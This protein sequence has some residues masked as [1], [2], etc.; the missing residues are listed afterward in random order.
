MTRFTV[1]P[2]IALVG[3]ALLLTSVSARAAEQVGVNAAVKGKVT[4]QSG[5]T[6]AQQAEIKKPVFLGDEVNSEK[7][8]ALQVMLKDQSVFTVGPQC[9]L[10]IDKFV[11][12]PSN[13][14]NQISANVKKGMFRFMSGKVSKSNPDDVAIDTPV[15]SMGIRG[16]IV[17]GLVGAEAVAY[18]INAGIITAGSP[19]D[20]AG[21]TLV[22]LRGPG[23]ANQGKD[24][25]GLV[26]ITSGGRTARLTNA[27][28][29]AFV[30][31][32]NSAPII[33]NQVSDE[34]FE[35]FSE[36]LR[37]RPNLAAGYM[38]FNYDSVITAGVESGVLQPLDDLDNPLLSFDWP[39]DPGLIFED[40]EF[41]CGP[42]NPNF[43]GCEALT[44][45]DDMDDMN[46]MQDT[47][48]IPENE[49]VLI[50]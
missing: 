6:Q 28:M 26:T 31:D 18:A 37:T 3:A 39:T 7:K 15:A 35:K 33:I 41:P 10:T 4:I 23:R 40:G 16:T 43:P 13:N 1:F 30:P 42:G 29:G 19:V 14:N 27:G 21:A 49:D 47:D 17:E 34:M 20:S 36:F 22:I 48:T 25:R 44:P 46:D 32:A 45:M 9:A 11:Y 8:S 2:R 50:P 24:R 12:D 38:P 5:A